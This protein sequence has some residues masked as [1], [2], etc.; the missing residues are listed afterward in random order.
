MSTKYIAKAMI[1]KMDGKYYRVGDTVLQADVSASIKDLVKAGLVVAN[2]IK[3]ETNVKKSEK[4][5]SE[6]RAEDAQ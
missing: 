4:D 5:N 1:Q 3:K 2:V 6:Q